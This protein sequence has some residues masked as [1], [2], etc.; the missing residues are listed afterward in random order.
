MWI[1]RL[2]GSNRYLATNPKVMSSTL[3]R[4][5]SLVRFVSRRRY[6]HFAANTIS[7]GPDYTL[8]ARNPC[9]RVESFFREKLRKRPLE[10]LDQD[11]PYQLKRHQTIFYPALGVSLDDPLQ[12]QVDALLSL[13]F[14]RFV[15]LLPGIAHLEDHLNP[16]TANYTRRVLGYKW[17]LPFDHIVQMEDAPA[18]RRLADEFH[19]DLSERANQTDDESL[20]WSRESKATVAALYRDDFRRLRYVAPV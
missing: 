3:Q 4:Q 5:Q 11:R 18:L 15:S 16:Q 10:A 12:T 7:I 13:D 14:D 2:K 20:E 9:T 8:L 17:V 6:L 1:F 19:L